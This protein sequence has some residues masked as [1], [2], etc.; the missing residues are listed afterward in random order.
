MKRFKILFYLTLAFLL[1]V[2]ITA[3]NHKAKA[4]DR[5]PGYSEWST[6]PTGEEGEI[7][8]KLYGYKDA[9]AYSDQ[10][11]ESMPG[12][13][14]Y[15]T[16]SKW[17]MTTWGSCICQWNLNDYCLDTGQT[18]WQDGAGVTTY[19]CK[20]GP[21]YS[22]ADS[23]TCGGD[24][25]CSA[26]QITIYYPVSEWGEEQGWR[27]DTPYEKT[28]SRMPLE[29]TVYSHPL[30]YT[31]TLDDGQVIKIKHGQTL[32]SIK[33]PTRKGYIFKGFFDEQ[34]RQFY[35]DK[36]D[37]TVVY[38][39]GMSTSLIAR[40]EP[41]TY[42]VNYQGGGA[43]GSTTSQTLKYDEHT[44]VKSCGYTK[45]GY[46]FSYW[47]DDKGKFYSPGETIVGLTDVNNGIYNLHAVWVK[48][49][50]VVT[51]DKTKD[52]TKESTK[53]SSK[54]STTTKK[55]VSSSDTI[56]NKGDLDS[57]YYFLVRVPQELIIDNNTDTIGIEVKGKLKDNSSLKLQLPNT[58]Y[59]KTDKFVDYE[60]KLNDLNAIKASE[61]TDTFKEIDISLSNPFDN[62]DKYNVS[63]P[64]T[65]EVTN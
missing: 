33:V 47:E 42:T 48:S 60:M 61:L 20:N 4:Q 45:N 13:G 50:D 19:K 2:N 30:T 54:D 31:I 51:K 17:R 23:N 64:L 16:T 49:E 6:T 18:C 3:V 43:S 22:Y 57:E 12:D 62:N 44:T 10:G 35:D 27:M 21:Y 29:A 8:S 37:S 1:T 52:S 25:T 55:K 39:E 59:L 34:G 9:I 36:G 46:T 53:D 40:W 24:K 26:T 32:P 41:I 58:L 15:T 63:F 7:S 5:L 28:N 56:V 38:E 11:S 14:F 65:I